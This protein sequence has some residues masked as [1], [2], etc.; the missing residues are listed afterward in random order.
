ML[1]L[2]PTRIFLGEEDL[3]Y[4][5]GRVYLRQTESAAGFNTD[6]TDSDEDGDEDEYEDEDDK[7][8]VGSQ[9]FSPYAL[10]HFKASSS[11]STRVSSKTTTQLSEQ[12]KIFHPSPTK[13]HPSAYSVTFNPL[14]KILTRLLQERLIVKTTTTSAALASGTQDLSEPVVAAESPRSPVVE[15]LRNEGNSEAEERDRVRSVMSI[16]SLAP[17][18]NHVEIRPRHEARAEANSFP[19]GLATMRERDPVAST[20]GPAHL[21]HDRESQ[22]N[23][24]AS[25]RPLEDPTAML[26]HPSDAKFRTEAQSIERRLKRMISEEKGAAERTN[27]YDYGLGALRRKPLGEWYR[28]AVN[29]DV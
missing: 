14:V 25:A 27:I 28:E 11:D 13:T 10:S 17:A 12:S 24:A 16:S 9:D 29:K 22:Q 8:S 4:H 19:S 26:A 20:T 18:D 7:T 2:G 23:G 5:L 3:R 1:R 15:R 6:Q 21:S